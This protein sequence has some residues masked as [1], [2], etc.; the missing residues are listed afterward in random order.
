MLTNCTM[1]AT[2]CPNCLC[3]GWMPMSV[4][5]VQTR[6]S[7]KRSQS[8]MNH[9]GNESMHVLFCLSILFKLFTPPTMT[10]PSSYSSSMQNNSPHQRRRKQLKWRM[11]SSACAT[12]W[13]PP[14]CTQ[15]ICSVLHC[16]LPGSSQGVNFSPSQRLTSWGGHPPSSKHGQHG[17]KLSPFHGTA[18]PGCGAA[19]LEPFFWFGEKRTEENHQ[20]QTGCKLQNTSRP[21][22]S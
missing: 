18:M 13:Q 19:N 6:V 12:K 11:R 17:A 4:Q 1:F 8:S 16:S 7:G 5:P 10:L 14:W 9:V 15:N 22:K 21:W 2:S 3:Q 20:L